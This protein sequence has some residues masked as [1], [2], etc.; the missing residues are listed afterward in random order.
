MKD[1]LNSCSTAKLKK[2][3]STSQRQAIIKLIEKKDKDKK[4]ITNW[5][6]IPLSNMDYKIYH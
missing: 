4:I 6:P 3:L 5:R 1:V 2:E